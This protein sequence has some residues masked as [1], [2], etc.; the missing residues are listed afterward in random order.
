MTKMKTKIDAGTLTRLQV[1]MVIKHGGTDYRVDL[2]NESRARCVPLE[3]VKVK[4]VM[5]DKRSGTEKEVEFSRSGG[6]ISISPNSEVE[7][8]SWK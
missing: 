7:I 4:Q 8:V 6:A 3:K 1:G 2:V 5:F